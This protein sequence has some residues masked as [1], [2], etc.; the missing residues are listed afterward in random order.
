MEK[1]GKNLDDLLN[2]N[3]ALIIRFLQQFTSCSRADLSKASGLTQATITKIVRDLLDTGLV[4]ETGFVDGRKGRRSIGL[5][6]NRDRYKVIGVKLSRGSISSCV[7]NIAGEKYE[8]EQS[9]ITSDENVNTVLSIMVEQ[10]RTLLSKH[11]DIIAIG[12]AVPGPYLKK[13][14]RIELIT[15]TGGWHD[16]SI[17]DALIDAFDLPVFIEHDA[18]AGALAYYWMGPIDVAKKECIVHVLASEGIGAGVLID[19]K[20]VTGSQGIAGE[21]G[22]IS[23]DYNGIPCECGNYGCLEK[24]CSSKSFEKNVTKQLLDNRGSILAGEGEI[25]AQKVF[26]AMRKKDAFATRMVEE[27]GTFLARGI[28][29]IVYMYNPSVIVISDIMSGGGDVLL[30][31]IKYTLKKQLLSVVYDNLTVKL[32]SIDDDLIRLGAGVVAFDSILAEP[33]RY[34]KRDSAPYP[35][36]RSDPS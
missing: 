1:Q 20:I 32:C 9:A 14:G 28:I 22:H 27:V 30:D 13:E 15:D 19:G 4:I 10:I 8:S 24:Y 34:L 29:T 5:K 25:T 18:N 11:Q 12:V 23:I 21:V 16:I 2:S 7:Y 17:R 36:Q 35:K 33:M 6:L 3:R 26:E 31:S